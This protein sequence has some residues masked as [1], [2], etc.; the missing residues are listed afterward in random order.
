MGKLY[1]IEPVCDLE[2]VIP[3]PFSQLFNDSKYRG[4]LQLLVELG[5]QSQCRG[6]GSGYSSA[7]LVGF[8]P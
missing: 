8:A 6:L 5:I 3:L 7:G 4:K 1:L 2:I